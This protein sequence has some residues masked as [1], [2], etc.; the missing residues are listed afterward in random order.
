[1]T[2]IL[3]LIVARRSW[4]W[5][6][7]ALV[8]LGCVMLVVDVAFLGANLM[9]FTSGGWFPV[10]LGIVTFT[11]MATW[12]RGR[13]LL[14]DRLRQESVPLKPVIRSLIDG[15]PVRVPGTALFLTNDLEMT[16]QAFL[17]NLKHN[18]VLHERNVF[19]S[20]E[21]REEPIAEPAQRVQ[22]ERLGDGFYRIRA[23]FGFAEHPDVPTA[24]ESCAVRG[25]GFDLMDTTFF[26]SRENIISGERTG[27][28]GWRDKLFAYLA[29]NSMPATASFRIPDNRL[30]EIGR[31]V[32]I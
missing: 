17:H 19:M 3:A 2:T 31:R 12:R 5:P 8:P 25:L 1:M 32:S 20:L 14:G 16:P 10:A 26:T 27:M 21:V 18:K 29:R 4:H 15:P 11:V 6:L 22:V 23:R 24:L 9:K 13:E 7:V 30:I 28:A